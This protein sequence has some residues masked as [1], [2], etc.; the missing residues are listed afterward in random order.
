M[1]NNSN[2]G[3]NEREKVKLTID[4]HP[5]FQATSDS[6]LK[7]SV[8]LSKIIN[9]LFRG[10]FADYV[11]CRIFVDTNA[12]I[13]MESNPL[14]NMHPVQVELYFLAGAKAQDGKLLAFQPIMDKIA[15]EY[16]PGK[17]AM[18]YT[19]A[20]LGYN[21]V[22]QTN[23]SCELTQGAIDIFQTMLFREVAMQLGSNPTA[24]AFAERGVVVE[25]PTTSSATPYMTPTTQVVVYNMV[26]CIDINSLLDF[27][28][29]KPEESKKIY[30]VVPIK[31]TTMINGQAQPINVG[32]EPDQRWLF[33]VMRLDQRNF[34]DK[35]NELGNFNIGTGLNICTE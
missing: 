27:I 32:V 1:G 5:D 24:A 23:K 25:K 26:R 34:L 33:N 10:T 30:N 35:C 19:Q 2:N 29:S 7:T 3:N 4:Q 18:N 6:S 22:M 8:D 21:A 15:Q 17:G 28:Y 9:A 11:G 12:N 31:P 16:K 20:T 14:S 13:G